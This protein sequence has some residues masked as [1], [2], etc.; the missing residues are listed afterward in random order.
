MIVTDEA[1]GSP[2]ERRDAHCK[3]DASTGNID[4]HGSRR[5]LRRDLVCCTE[6]RSATKRRAQRDPAR[7]SNYYPLAPCRIVV[8]IIG[9]FGSFQSRAGSGLRYLAGGYLCRHVCGCSMVCFASFKRTLAFSIFLSRGCHLFITSFSLV[10][11]FGDA[12]QMPTA[13][14]TNAPRDADICPMLYSV[15]IIAN[16]IPSRVK[17]HW[18]CG[19]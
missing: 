16:S 12:M 9:R 8:T 1:N 18:F 6:Q 11:A 3:Q 10:E 19:F 4:A 5:E 2:D 13:K 17:A 15:Y 7:D 14:K